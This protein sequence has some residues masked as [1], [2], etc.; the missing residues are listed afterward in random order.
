LPG[1]G[2]NEQ[3][4][5]R[6]SIPQARV[7]CHTRGRP[8]IESQGDVPRRPALAAGPPRRTSRPF[9]GR[10]AAGRKGEAI[11]TPDAHVAQC[12]LDRDAL[13]LSRDD[14]FERIARLQP[15]RVR[16]G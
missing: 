13:L 9:F 2:S 11:S 15:L 12:A 4:L 16:P 5:P 14:V 10:F 7:V 8:G 3:A 6:G 1:L